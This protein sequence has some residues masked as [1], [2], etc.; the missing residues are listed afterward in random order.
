[1]NPA[2]IRVVT[3]NGTEGTPITSSA[4]TSSLMRIEPSCAVK[5]APTVADR[6]RPDTRGAISRVL[7]Y[8][9]RNATKL[10]V[11]SWLSAAY[12]CRPTSVPVKKDRKAITPTVP[13]TT[14]S[15][16]R[17]KLTSASRR[18]GCSTQ[19]ATKRRNPPATPPSQTRWSNARVS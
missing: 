2:I 11:P 12:P 19:S 16:P 3:R 14:A 9:D 13:P 4:S 10:D 18:T 5:P 15:A 6:A 17:P 1:M 7:K 8:A